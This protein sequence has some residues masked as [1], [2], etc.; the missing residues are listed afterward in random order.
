MP[1]LALLGCLY[2]IRFVRPSKDW[3]GYFKL[4]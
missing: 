4:V 1:G 2:Q 3:L